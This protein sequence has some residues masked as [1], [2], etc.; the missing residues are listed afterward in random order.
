MSWTSRIVCSS[1]VRGA[2]LRTFSTTASVRASAQAPERLVSFPIFTRKGKKFTQHNRATPVNPT[3]LYESEGTPIFMFGLIAFAF[4]GYACFGLFE[5]LKPPS[6][7]NK[8]R[9][10][11]LAKEGSWAV[12]GLSAA[13][14]AT[15]FLGL[16]MLYFSGFRMVR[17]LELIPK[18][19]LYRLDVSNFWLGTRRVDLQAKKSAFWAPSYVITV[20]EMNVQKIEAKAHYVMFPVAN[21]KRP[22]VLGPALVQ[23]K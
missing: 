12:A 17:R 6:W 18:E 19:N 16:T 11:N 14:T 8:Y 2:G 1:L 13:C 7:K 9:D 22:D 5:L 15:G 4:A 21:W 10:R 3:V 20:A 23:S